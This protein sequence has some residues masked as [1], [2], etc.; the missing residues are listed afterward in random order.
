MWCGYCLKRGGGIQQKI[1]S[2]NTKRAG[3][4]PLWKKMDYN[5]CI[6][7]CEEKKMKK[8]KGTIKCD[9]SMVICDVGII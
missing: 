1:Y 4:L 6:I 5:V 9:K 8:E 7:Q 3:R 2:I